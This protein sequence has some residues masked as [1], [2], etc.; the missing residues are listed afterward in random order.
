[1]GCP[2]SEGVLVRASKVAMRIWLQMILRK[3]LIE[4]AEVVLCSCIRLDLLMLAKL[5]GW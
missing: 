1:M 4:I 2:N 3:S 5:L